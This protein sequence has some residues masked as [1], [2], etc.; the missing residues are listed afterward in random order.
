MFKTTRHGTVYYLHEKWTRLSVLGYVKDKSTEGMAELT[1]TPLKQ[2]FPERDR[3]NDPEMN[4][5][6]MG[7]I[8]ADHNLFDDKVKLL[9]PWFRCNLLQVQP[10]ILGSRIK[11]LLRCS[12]DS[13]P[14]LL[15]DTKTPPDLF[16]VNNDERL[17]MCQRKVT[18]SISL[19]IQAY[20]SQ[21]VILGD[22]ANNTDYW[23]KGYLMEPRSF[24][25]GTSF[26][27]WVAEDI[28]LPVD[29]SDEIL[30]KLLLQVWLARTTPVFPP[31]PEY[32]ELWGK[33]TS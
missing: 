21:I 25:G 10:E 3:S 29:V 17:R 18:S 16:I 15:T 22:V 26:S 2:S 24:S 31:V 33:I 14:N 23:P 11:Y 4:D 32:V 7:Q 20:D 1:F 6:V 5:P 9:N 13:Y 19:E 8:L 27:W 28:T 12:N 30:G